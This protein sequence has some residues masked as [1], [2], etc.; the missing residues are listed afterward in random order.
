MNDTSVPTG[1]IWPVTV[2]RFRARER[3]G[4]GGGAVRMIQGEGT[5]L[6]REPVW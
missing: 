6:G 3:I 1:N 2:N 4:A 5:S